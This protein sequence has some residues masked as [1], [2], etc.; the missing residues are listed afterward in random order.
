MLNKWKSFNCRTAAKRSFSS[1]ADYFKKLKES[2]QNSPETM[3]MEEVVHNSHDL[4]VQIE[5]VS[6]LFINTAGNPIPAVY[7]V[8]LGF[9][10]ANGAG[11][12][13]LMRMITGSLP[14]SSGSIEIFGTQIE[15]IKDKTVI[16]ICP[17]FNTHLLSELAPNEHF[18]IYSWIFQKDP[19][20]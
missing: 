14:K 8:C 3:K 13:T 16:S 5:D 9:L 18:K 7:N 19:E 10:G 2:T 15:D 11:K 4:I 6:R 17:Q 20:E 12:T 1:Y